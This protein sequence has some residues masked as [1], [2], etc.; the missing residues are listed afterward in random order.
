M[1][2]AHRHIALLTERVASWPLGY[3]HRTPAECNA[4]ACCALSLQNGD[5]EYASLG[6]P[7]KLH[8]TPKPFAS[9]FGC[10]NALSAA[11]IVGRQHLL[12][13]EKEDTR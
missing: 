11:N 9:N 10:S 12:I 13:P 1:Y 5:P 3:K 4:A 2:L 6:L 8:P 7:F